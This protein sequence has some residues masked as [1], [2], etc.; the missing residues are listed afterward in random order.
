MDVDVSQLHQELARRVTF[1]DWN[2][3]FLDKNKLAMLGFYYVGQQDVVKC[4]FC[5]V[6]IGEWQPDDDIL[7]EHIKYSP[8]CKL[9]TG[10]HTNNIPLDEVLLKKTLPPPRTPDV[11]GFG[12]DDEVYYPEMSSEIR[13]LES[14]AKWPKAMKQRPSEMSAAGFFYSGIGDKV[15]CFSCGCELESWEEDD[16]PWT[17]HLKNNTANCKNLKNAP[18]NSEI[19]PPIGDSDE[20]DFCKICADG[21]CNIVFLPCFHVGTCKKCA[22]VLTSCPWCRQV[23]TERKR[24]FFIK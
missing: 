16:N 11:C 24:A 9:I 2:V 4:V 7:T 3:D 5:N 15:I 19:I 22:D 17:E 12:F 13:R 10:G 6:A 1:V 8:N 14:F 23:I 21:E 20:N 18:V